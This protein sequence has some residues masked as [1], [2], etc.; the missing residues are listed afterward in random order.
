MLPEY[1]PL[2]IEGMGLDRL[3]RDLHNGHNNN[4]NVQTEKIAEEEFLLPSYFHTPEE[5]DRNRD[6]YM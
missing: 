2:H 6:D 1:P 3:A 5:D 4:D